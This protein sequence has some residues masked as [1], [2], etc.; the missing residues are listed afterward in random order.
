MTKWAVDVLS[1]LDGKESNHFVY[2]IDRNKVREGFVKQLKVAH[3]KNLQNRSD[4]MVWMEGKHL[5]MYNMS[6]F[7]ETPP[8]RMIQAFKDGIAGY[9]TNAFY[10]DT[11]KYRYEI[12]FYGAVFTFFDSVVI[13]SLDH[14]VG[15][16]PADHVTTIETGRREYF[17]KAGAVAKRVAEEPDF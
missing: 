3:M 1:R 16:Q 10:Q 7:F 8:E 5:H 13:H 12:V 11:K 17:R 15:A 9:S 14:D 4:R 6:S 2:S